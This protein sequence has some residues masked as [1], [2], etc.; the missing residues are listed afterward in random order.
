MDNF[1]IEYWFG[2]IKTE[3]LND[4]DYSEITFD[5][6]NLKIKEY[7]DLYNKERIQSNLEWKT[8]QQTAMML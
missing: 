6:L 2:I 1:E 8:P 4:L 5:E 3:L 7:V